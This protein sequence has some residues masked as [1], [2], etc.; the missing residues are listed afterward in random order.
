MSWC[1]Q[2]ED[3][4]TYVI[5]S[6][7]GMRNC[8]RMKLAKKSPTWQECK[9]TT[10]GI[11]AQAVKSKQE[12]DLIVSDILHHMWATVIVMP[13]EILLCNTAH[14][15]PRLLQNGSKKL[16]DTFVHDFLDP[17]IDTVFGSADIFAL[18][19]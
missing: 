9:Q 13:F 14:S 10:I 4:S 12:I 17:V 7:Y 18:H 5:F 2:V 16:E 19:W 8:G 1:Q 6:D 11:L 15:T 3:V